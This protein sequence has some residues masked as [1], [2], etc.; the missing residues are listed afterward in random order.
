MPYAR[1]RTYRKRSTRPTVRKAKQIVTKIRKA[2]AKR[3]QDTFFLKARVTGMCVPA[4]G[5]T[6]AN[7]ISSFWKLLDSGSAVGVTNNAEFRLFS[8][9][10]DRVRVNSIKVH[11]TPK[12]N[13]NTAFD[14]QDDAVKTNNGDGMVHTCVLRG[15]DG[16]QQS[17]SRLSRLPSYKPFSL[18]KKWSRSYSVKYPMGVWLDCQNIYSDQTLLER[19]GLSGGIGIYGENLLEDSGETYN[20]PVASVVIEY[21]CVFQGKIMSNL[22]F[23]DETEEMCIAKPVP[24]PY[25]P[26]DLVALQGTTIYDGRFDKDGAVVPVDDGGDAP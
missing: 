11:W 16:F 24:T 18:L 9:M 7:Y 5:V 13:V 6:V 3:N 17:I 15:Q 25:T 1:R 21:N 26:T 20:E 14:N 19:L 10:Y 8:N 12:A 23:N 4:Q 2:K 22:S